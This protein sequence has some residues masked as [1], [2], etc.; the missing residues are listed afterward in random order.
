MKLIRAFIFFLP[1]FG[2]IWILYLR[3]FPH[4]SFTL[5]CTVSHCSKLITGLNPPR[6]ELYRLEDEKMW[7]NLN[8]SFSL[9]AKLLQPYR[10]LEIMMSIPSDYFSPVEV[11]LGQEEGVF[12]ASKLLYFGLAEFLEKEWMRLESDEFILFQ[13]RKIPELSS[14]EQFLEDLPPLK[15]IAQFG[16]DFRPYYKIPGYQPTDKELV[17]EQDLV[18]THKMLT[19]IKDEALEF[20]LEFL[21]RRFNDAREVQIEV[22]HEYGDHKII[23]TRALKVS[24]G[25]ADLNLAGLREGVYGIRM[26]APDDVVWSQIRTRQHWVVFDTRIQLR[27]SEESAIV[28]H[29]FDHVPFE[30]TP[31]EEFYQT[32]LFALARDQNFVP[33]FVTLDNVQDLGTTNT[34]DLNYLLIRKP[35]PEIEV[36]GA[37]QK[38]L[39]SFSDIQ[40]YVEE[41]RLTLN[42]KTMPP[43]GQGFRFKE[44]QLTFKR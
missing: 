4:A 19:Y 13:R 6:G 18:G 32:G 27:S 37:Y 11:A 9:N 2:L 25:Q 40:S 10:S 41:G 8:H 35:L 23:E 36:Q 43:L 20:H 16:F 15:S 30:L 5:K 26:Q 33:P 29:G 12:K 39:V 1:V 21:S 31:G 17:L 42:I 28:Y 14:I 34:A 3:F 24:D 7:I 38:L 22:T 44:V